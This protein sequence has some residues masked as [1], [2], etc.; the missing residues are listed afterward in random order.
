[1]NFVEALRLAKEHG[2]AIRHTSWENDAKAS[3][4]GGLVG[5]ELSGCF[6]FS[7]EALQSN[8]WCVVAQNPKKYTFPEAYALMKSG[9]KMKA[10]FQTVAE[11]QKS[12]VA[13]WTGTRLKWIDGSLYRSNDVVVCDEVINAQWEKLS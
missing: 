7:P 3:M 5:V 1:M 9:E 10:T 6:Y 2:K 4:S 12:L 11:G 13:M 8:N